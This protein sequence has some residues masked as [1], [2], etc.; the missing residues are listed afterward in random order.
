M[1]W[2]WVLII[3]FKNVKLPIESHTRNEK[4]KLND[5]LEGTFA[6]HIASRAKSHY[7]INSFWN[8]V[9]MNKIRKT[10]DSTCQCRRHRFKPLSKKTP[11][12]TEQL[13]HVAQLLSLC[14][15]VRQQLLLLGAQILKPMGPTAH[16]LQQER[17]LQW[18]AYTLRIWR[19]AR[20]ATKMQTA[21]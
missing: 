7:C 5:P 19:K 16:A 14:L 11:H 8:Q 4:M 15:V 20:A 17:P 13:R 10:K 2:Y 9:E 1:T 18:V 3:C 21:I 6:K 12:T